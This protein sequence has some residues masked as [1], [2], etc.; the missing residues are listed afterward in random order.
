M[1]KSKVALLCTAFFVAGFALFF[2]WRDFI[3]PSEET[4]LMNQLAKEEL[5]RQKQFKDDVV[6]NSIISRLQQASLALSMF[7]M[8]NSKEIGENYD[9]GAALNTLERIREKLGD[10]YADGRWIFQSNV[11]GWWIGY[12]LDGVS[13]ADRQKIASKAGFFNLFKTTDKSDANVYD[14]GDVVFLYD[15]V[16]Q[17]FKW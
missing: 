5:K 17:T 8:K 9:L 1:T 11:A 10:T 3:A 15:Y 4:K 13:E 12:K 16:P 6:A 14:G 2:F 7:R